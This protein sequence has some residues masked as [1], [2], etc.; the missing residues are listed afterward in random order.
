LTRFLDQSDV[1]GCTLTSSLSLDFLSLDFLFFDDLDLGAGSLSA[2]RWRATSRPRLE[3]PLQEFLLIVFIALL[4]LL[5]ILE[6]LVGRF[7]HF[8]VALKLS[9]SVEIFF[10]FLKLANARVCYTEAVESLHVIRVF[11]EG[12][13]AILYRMVVVLQIQVAVGEIDAHDNLDVF[14]ELDGLLM[15]RHDR[16]FIHLKQHLEGEQRLVIMG[17]R[18]L[19]VLVLNAQVPIV[20]LDVGHSKLLI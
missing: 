10:S 8:F 7:F 14:N 6:G 15:R 16:V 2:F 3:H 11:L 19:I 17:D 20:A 9:D 5:H 13:R 1:L 4:D 18:L 12:L